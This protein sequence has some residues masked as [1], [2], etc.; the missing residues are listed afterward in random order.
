MDGDDDVKVAALYE[1]FECRLRSERGMGGR[2]EGER[3]WSKTYDKSRYL[4]VSLAR[5]GYL[6][7]SYAP[8]TTASSRIKQVITHLEK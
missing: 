2:D 8:I 7:S 3:E 4:E 5:L 6:H 1:A